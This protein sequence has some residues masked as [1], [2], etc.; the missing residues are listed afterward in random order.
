MGI[1]YRR[2]YLFYG[3]PGC[4]KSSFIKA[5]A[6]HFGL[7]VCL[8]TLSNR[9][10]TDDALTVLL[11]ETPRRCIIVIEDIDAAVRSRDALH[12]EASSGGPSHGITLSGLLNALDGIASQEG[13]ILILTTNKRHALD[14]ALV[15]PGRVDK[16]IYFDLASRA[17]LA[18]YFRAFFPTLR[19]DAVAEF[20]RRVPDRTF[21]MAEVRL[22]RYLFFE[23]FGS[24]S[25]VLCCSHLAQHEPHMSPSADLL[26]VQKFMMS[27]VDRPLAALQD[28]ER[29]MELI[30]DGERR[31]GT[32]SPSEPRSPFR[33]PQASPAKD[34]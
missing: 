6:G 5:V 22:I 30:S 19:E 11:N 7:G 27:Y 9:E 10:L 25:K 18:D 28:A 2:G 33:T 17:Q 16:K 15:R 32:A 23:R 26:Q 14:D 4:G 29:M 3:P 12:S 21:S 13:R 1:P 24:Y 31:S 34:M 20:V 8:M